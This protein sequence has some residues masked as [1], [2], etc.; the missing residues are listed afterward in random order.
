MAASL[1]RPIFPLARAFITGQCALQPA[2]LSAI[3]RGKTGD[4]KRKA[5][6]ESCEACSSSHASR[7][8]RRARAR[9]HAPIQRLGHNGS[10][11]VILGW[12]RSDP[13]PAPSQPGSQFRGQTPLTSTLQGLASSGKERPWPSL[14]TMLQVA[15]PPVSFLDFLSSFF[16]QP[17]GPTPHDRL[18]IN[19]TC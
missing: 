7:M 6:L 5:L 12:R 19:W 2:V 1:S 11:G 9:Q 8:P 14:H 18:G 13:E 3:A 4:F 15:A 10:D 17:P 16:S